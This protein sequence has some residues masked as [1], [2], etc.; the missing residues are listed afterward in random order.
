MWFAQRKEIEFWKGLSLLGLTCNHL[1]LWPLASL[2]AGL[3]LTYQSVG[4]F[5]FAS[6]YF[7]AAGIIWGR[8]AQTKPKFWNWNIKRASMLL[9]WV[10]VAATVFQLGLTCQ[11]LSP[12]P[13]QRHVT[14]ESPGSILHALVGIKLPWLVDVIWLHACL[15]I[16]TALIWKLPGF[17][18][19]P[20]LVVGLSCLIWILSQTDVFKFNIQ[21]NQAPSWHSWTS[22]QLLFVLSA[23]S[24]EKKIQQCITKWINQKGK[25][26]VPVLAMFFIFL[27]I[28]TKEDL[29]FLSSAQKFAPLFALNSLIILTLLSSW[30]ENNCVNG[31]A[32]IGRF[33]LSGYSI[34][35]LMVYGLGSNKIPHVENKFISLLILLLSLLAIFFFSNIREMRR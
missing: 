33:S 28:S 14:W 5:T 30:K 32:K 13:W 17:K 3:R 10:A 11:I 8:T 29:D 6:I 34:Q 7:S 22:W 21:E 4:W 35:C 12:V 25:K 23:V 9:L 15:G 24:Q 2:S 1:F 20:K 18:D 16:F 27:K 26:V 19:R 31:I